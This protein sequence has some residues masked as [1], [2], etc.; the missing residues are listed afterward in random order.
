MAKVLAALFAALMTPPRPEV[1]E[2]ESEEFPLGDKIRFSTSG[3][4]QMDKEYAFAL[5]IS[6]PMDG[7]EAC[8]ARATDSST[9]TSKI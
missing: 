7:G 4:L 1:V 8:S 2:I 9:V 5:D 6:I 3:K